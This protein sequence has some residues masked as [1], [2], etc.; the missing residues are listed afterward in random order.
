MI[1][2]F[3]Q[4]EYVNSST[5]DV[6][7]SFLYHIKNDHG[8]IYHSELVNKLHMEIGVGSASEEN[9]QL[10]VNILPYDIVDYDTKEVDLFPLKNDYNKD[11]EEFIQGLPEKIVYKEVSNEESNIE[12]GPQSQKRSKREYNIGNYL[13]NAIKEEYAI[14]HKK[15][16]RRK[17]NARRNSKL[18]NSTNNSKTVSSNSNYSIIKMKRLEDDDENLIS[19]NG[20]L[21]RLRKSSMYLH[22]RNVCRRQIPC[23][24]CENLFED[25]MVLV[26]HK[27]E[28]HPYRIECAVKKIHS[29][30]Q[31]Q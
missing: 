27:V 2:Y 15:L 25:K 7:F 9:E 14:L 18:V 4:E 8:I 24:K 30:A 17:D 26:K 6:N 3:C 12:S 29:L 31:L 5:S 20:C 11:I 16:K 19:C 23:G 1:C 28:M 21:K 10:A 13:E 22:K